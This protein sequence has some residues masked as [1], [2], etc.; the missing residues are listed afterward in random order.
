MVLIMR[1]G[2]SST[3]MG[4]ISSVKSVLAMSCEPAGARKDCGCWAISWGVAAARP[5][6]LRKSRRCMRLSHSIRKSEPTS[7][8]SSDQ[9]TTDGFASKPFALGFAFV[10]KGQAQGI[11]ANHGIAVN[12]LS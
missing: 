8:A 9:F 12:L 3:V 4:A 6:I 11:D 1:L 5:A 10:N 2:A 7:Q